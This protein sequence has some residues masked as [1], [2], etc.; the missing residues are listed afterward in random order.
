MVEAEVVE[1]AKGIK[2][3]RGERPE[4]KERPKK[5]KS[6]QVG[7]Y[8]KEAEMYSYAP[9][10]ATYNLFASDAVPSPHQF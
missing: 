8:R 9:F 3:G 4:R 2:K 7:Y 10:V 1:A 6:K 5:D